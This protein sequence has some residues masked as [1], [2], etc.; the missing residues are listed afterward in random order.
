MPA[1]AAILSALPSQIPWA[2]NH[3]L[4]T[5][6]E[7]HGPMTFPSPRLLSYLS[8]YISSTAVSSL[9]NCGVL[10]TCKENQ[11]PK[12]D[13]STTA[14]EAQIYVVIAL[15]EV[16]VQQAT[17]ARFHRGDGELFISEVSR[18]RG[19]AARSAHLLRHIRRASRV[20]ESLTAALRVQIRLTHSESRFAR[21]PSCNDSLPTICHLEDQVTD[22]AN[23]E[24]IL[25]GKVV[26]LQEQV[27]QI[28]RQQI[29][30][31]PIYSSF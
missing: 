28:R 15:L 21:R 14:F 22:L 13:M 17:L 27:Q 11:T 24:N 3:S 20:R 25:K 12:G 23:Q 16:I 8:P 5:A 9:R 4:S 2:A 18:M 7:N 26:I 31:R 19:A 29:R 30:S 6:N 1:A 10:V